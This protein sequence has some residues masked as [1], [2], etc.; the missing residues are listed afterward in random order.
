[1]YKPSTTLLLGRIRLMKRRNL[2]GVNVVISLYKKG[3]VQLIRFL[4][5]Y[6]PPSKTGVT[7][8]WKRM[9]HKET[10]VRNFV[11]SEIGRR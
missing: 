10:P 4:L 1:M 3:D 8:D 5:V 2:L 6:K 11:L 7:N 9:T